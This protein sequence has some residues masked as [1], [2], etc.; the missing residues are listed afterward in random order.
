[1]LPWLVLR[2]QKCR[3]P[4]LRHLKCHQDGKVQV[5]D[6][7]YFLAVLRYTSARSRISLLWG[8]RHQARSHQKASRRVFLQC[9][10]LN[11]PNVHPVRRHRGFGDSRACRGVLYVRRGCVLPNVRCELRLQHCNHN[12]QQVRWVRRKPYEYQRQCDTGFAWILLGR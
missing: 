11:L 5:G 3:R 7:V 1:M 4:F 10:V 6:E 9:C 12:R 2:N 8:R